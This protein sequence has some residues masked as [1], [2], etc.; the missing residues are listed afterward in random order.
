VP[1]Y[2]ILLPDE[3]DAF[4]AAGS[5][6]GSAFDR[7]SGF[8][9]L[10]SRDQVAE[11]ARHVFADE[12]A[13]VIAVIDDDVVRDTLRWE[14]TSDRGCFPHAY[15]TLPLAAVV[16]VVRVAGATDVDGALPPE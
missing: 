13:L 14:T 4:E 2:K 5:F 15:G 11:T 16:A 10:S 12:P 7:E 6:G 1:I 3:W 8:I 9:H